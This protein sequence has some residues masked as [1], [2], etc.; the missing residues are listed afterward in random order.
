MVALGTTEAK[1]SSVTP[2]IPALAEN[3]KFKH[4]DINSWFALM[5]PA[6]LPAPVAAKLKAALNETLQS[7]AFRAKMEATGNVLASPKVDMTAFLKTE[8]AKYK[9]IVDAANIEE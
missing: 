1:R 2:D 9:K 4:V 8:V 6:K 3:P 7:P 5:G